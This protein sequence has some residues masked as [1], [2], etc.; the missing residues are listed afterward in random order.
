MSATTF[1][2]CPECDGTG[3]EPLP[4]FVSPEMERDCGFCAGEGQV[5]A[6]GGPACDWCDEAPGTVDVV[7]W[8]GNQDRVCAACWAAAQADP[9]GH[10]DVRL[11]G[12]P[13]EVEGLVL[14]AAA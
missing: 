8:Q 6:E 5:P 3:V 1:T 14:A 11:A 7:D 4:F 12:G 9:A 10:G 2:T 13:V